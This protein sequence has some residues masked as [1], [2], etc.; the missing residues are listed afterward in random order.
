MTV[1][2]FISYAHKDRQRVEDVVAVLRKGGHAPWFDERLVAGQDWKTKLRQEIL[3]S[4]ALVFMASPRSAT[5]EWC[6]WELSIAA[7]SGKPIVPVLLEQTDLPPALAAL[8][9]ADFTSAEHTDAVAKLMGGLSEIAE[10]IPKESLPKAPDEPRG[11]P[12]QAAGVHQ[13]VTVGNVIGGRV[14]IVG[15]QN[16]L[17][18]HTLRII[19]VLILAVL[20]L[21][22]LALMPEDDRNTLFYRLGLIPASATLTA[23]ATATPTPTPTLTPT[24]TPTPTP[25]LRNYDI[26][27]GVSYFVVAG[28]EGIDPQEAETLIDA[29]SLRLQTEL[30][31]AANTLGVSVGLHGPQGI[32]QVVGDD[33]AARADS[34]RIVAEALDAD[35]LVYGSI[36]RN[37]ITGGTEVIPVFYVSP[38]HFWDALEMTGAQHLGSPISVEAPISEAIKS[39]SRLIVRTRTVADIIAGLARYIN[40]DYAGALTSFMDAAANPDWEESAG[41]EVL[42]V[43]LG[44]T[45]LKLAQEAA[46][47]CQPENAQQQRQVILGEIAYAEEQYEQARTLSHSEYSRAFAGLASASLM[48]ALWES[49]EGGCNPLMGDP[50]RLSQAAE[51][52]HLAEEAVN[53]PSENTVLKKRDFTE[54][55]VLF[56]QWFGDGWDL[57]DDQVYQQFVRA[58]QTITSDYEN[59]RRP[60]LSL[61]AAEAYTLRAT[62]RLLTNDCEAAVADYDLALQITDLPPD[63]RMYLWEWKGWCNVQLGQLPTAAAEYAT[64]QALAVNLGNDADARAYQATREGIIVTLTQTAP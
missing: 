2:L 23:T 25:P 4:D 20:A 53:Q 3:A 29:F 26:G 51:Y 31:D 21:G 28:D 46:F 32:T 36:E 1:K 27:V 15:Q 63:R 49:P 57:S 7:E 5:S 10:F 11:E 39:R 60:E 14:T 54:A 38:D 42:Y 55:Q 62:G 58:T 43:L 52:L 19:L 8:H 16:N 41:G 35:I 17:S 33:E 44:N 48:S 18:P 13:Q 40:E 24:I 34:A 6:L 37:A 22:A 59:R 47:R 12:A 30:A 50:E 56:F 61:L 45:H 9:Y 64:A